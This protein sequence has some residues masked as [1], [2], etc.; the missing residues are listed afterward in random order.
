MHQVE[1][2]DERIRYRHRAVHAVAPL[3]ERFD[4]DLLLFEVDP[5]GGERKRLANPAAGVQVHAAEGQRDSFL[6]TR[7][8]GEGAALVLGQ[9]FAGV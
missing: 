2:I 3:L 6:Q 9:V 4:H 7:R 5:S 8:F 1:L